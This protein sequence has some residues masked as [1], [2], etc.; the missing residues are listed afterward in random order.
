M[1][2]LRKFAKKAIPVIAFILLMGLILS[3]VYRPDTELT[4][5]ITISAEQAHNHV[6]KTAKVCGTAASARFIENIGGKPTFINLGEPHP[7]QVFTI[8]IWENDRAAWSHPPEQLYRNRD[9][10]VTGRIQL[11]EGVPQII[12]ERPDQISVN[13][14]PDSPE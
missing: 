13:H 9:I 2:S 10:C 7:D 8:V 11:H 12:A 1:K 4:P 5:E 14:S 6:G 3:R